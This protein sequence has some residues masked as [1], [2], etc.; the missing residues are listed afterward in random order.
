MQTV[1]FDVYNCIVGYLEPLSSHFL[2]QTCKSFFSVYPKYIFGKINKRLM[3]VFGD[4]LFALKKMMQET[5]CVISGSFIIQCLIDES[6]EYSDI[7]FF[8]HMHNNKN[9]ESLV[10]DFLGYQWLNYN[11]DETYH[12]I[13]NNMI[14]KVKTY[15]HITNIY[16]I[17]FVSVD[18]SNICA[19]VNETFDFDICKNIYYHDGRDNLHVNNFDNILLKETNFRFP[20][21]YGF[22]A[23]ISRHHKYTRRGIKFKN[24]ITLDH[25]VPIKLDQK[26]TEMVM[27]YG[28]TDFEWDSVYQLSGDINVIEKYNKIYSSIRGDCNGDMCVINF[29]KAQMKHVHLCVYFIVEQCAIEF[30]ILYKK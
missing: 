1:P 7:D 15:E 22:E 3:K 24:R 16:R 9:Y 17:Q 26:Q 25:I 18:T 27:Q 10:T 28:F 6:W 19:F 14:K 29:L 8:I 13:K 30:A 2:S 23:A 20:T 21:I 5:G 11:P 12:S 4:Q